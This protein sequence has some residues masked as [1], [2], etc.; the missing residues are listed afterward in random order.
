MVPRE[1]PHTLHSQLAPFLSLLLERIKS[2]WLRKKKL[3]KSNDGAWEE[4]HFPDPMCDLNDSLIFCLFRTQTGLRQDSGWYFE[5]D[6]GQ[7][8]G[9]RGQGTGIFSGQDNSVFQPKLEE[10]EHPAGRLDE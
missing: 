9:D 6:R 10:I 2:I 8:T 4:V 3:Y 7:G 5:G 1:S